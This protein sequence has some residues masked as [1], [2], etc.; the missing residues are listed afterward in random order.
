[1]YCGQ[2]ITSENW[3][4]GVEISVIA[5][6]DGVIDGDK[7]RTVSLSGSVRSGGQDGV[8]LFPVTLPDTEVNENFI[9][10]V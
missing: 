4:N 8:E 9:I 6:Q 10:F 3:E 7:T 1:M 5:R 2:T